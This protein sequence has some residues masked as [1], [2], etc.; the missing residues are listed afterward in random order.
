MR[1][2]FWMVS[3]LLAALFSATAIQAKEAETH[4]QA[5][6]VI[7][8]TVWGL[9]LAQD[10]S[11]FYNEVASALLAHEGDQASYQLMPYKRA[12]ARFLAGQGDC[13]YPSSIDVLTAGGHVGDGSSLIETGQLFEVSTHLFAR[14]GQ[15][16]PHSMADLKGKSIAIPN[17]SVM[18][19]LLKGAG[20]TLLGVNDE[21]DK[22][23]M[24]LTGRVDL[25]SGMMPDTGLVFANLGEKVPAF[26][27]HFSFLNVGIALVCH[28][29]P[30]TEALV[31]RLN[32]RLAEMRE[33]S[34]YQAQLAR[35]GVVPAHLDEEA[36]NAIMPAAG[37][38]RT[39][40]RVAA[41][42]RM[43]HLKLR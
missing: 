13:L 33:D 10:G 9:T 3:G 35:A 23:R 36:L 5:A 16:P 38:D 34:A 27:P 43:P 12:K 20:A 26:D 25:M 17:G 21:S 8:A 41:G 39:Q 40:I 14:P 22:A 2:A 7:Y 6:P 19:E 29:K 1:I 28:R 4:N 37:A 11:G 15:E 32:T 30:E 42:R 24:L 18:A 31:G